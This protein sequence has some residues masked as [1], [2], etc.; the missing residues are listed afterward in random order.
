MI[1]AIQ[2]LPIYLIINEESCFSYYYL[3]D[4]SSWFF[5]DDNGA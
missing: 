1:P 5:D 4:K 3:E 2:F